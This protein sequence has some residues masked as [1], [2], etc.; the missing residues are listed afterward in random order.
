MRTAGQHRPRQL[1]PESL[2]QRQI[3]EKLAPLV[4]ILQDAGR[5]LDSWVSRIYNA[6]RRNREVSDACDLTG[7]GTNLGH[8]ACGSR[9]EIK[10]RNSGL[11]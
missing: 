6:N 5:Y 10:V 3:G 1:V 2:E 7:M 9:T 8:G 11:G 4:R